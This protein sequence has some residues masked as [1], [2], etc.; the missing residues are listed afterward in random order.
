MNT[1]WIFTAFLF[2]ADTNINEQ[3]EQRFFFNIEECI[4]FSQKVIEEKE[5][6]KDKP[7][8]LHYTASCTPRNG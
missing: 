4:A 2:N 5:N 7:P 6:A 1:I 8:Q 3:I